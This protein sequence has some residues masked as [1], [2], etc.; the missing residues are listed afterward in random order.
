M[1]QTEYPGFLGRM[2]IRD[3]PILPRIGLLVS[4][5]VVID[6]A[7][8]FGTRL[9]VEDYEAPVFVW[10]VFFH[11]YFWPSLVLFMIAGVTLRGRLWTDWQSLALAPAIR[12]YIFGLALLLAW[13]SAIYA[14]NHFAD[15]AHWL[16]RALVV[17]SL[18]LIWVRPVFVFPFLVMCYLSMFQLVAPGLGGPIIAHKL[19]VFQL[20]TAFGGWFLLRLW[21]RSFTATDLLF[22]FLCIIAGRYW[23]PGLAKVLLGWWNAGDITRG[24]LGSWVHGWL[25]HLSADGIVALARRFEPYATILGA[26]VLV[27][28]LG[29]L[30]IL[31]HRR[32]AIALLAF[33][34]VFHSGVFFLLGFMFWIWVTVDF[35][36]ICLL[37]WLG[38]QS[39]PTPFL[40]P[41]LL[42]SI[43]LIALSA[44]W[45]R[46]PHLGWFD[47]GLTYN[48]RITAIGESGTRYSVPPMVFAPFNDLFT[49]NAFNYLT[50]EYNHLTASYGITT[51]REIAH[52]I[53]T[54]RSAEE[55]FAL[56]R[57]W[58]G[59][60][61][62]D[63][64]RA[65]NFYR[66]VTQHFANLNAN[67]PRLT[68]LSRIEPPVHFWALAGPDAYEGQEPV[69]AV[70]FTGV[71]WFFDGT[72]L[73]K[74]RDVLLHR[75]EVP[76]P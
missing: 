20:L 47:T 34:I 36:T 76:S 9:S 71:T 74:I 31:A 51:S 19:I 12:L 30:F 44:F 41:Y 37:I 22:V 62:P 26:I 70:E 27:A 61:V 17:V 57:Q 52:G 38:R 63:A 40:R 64:V 24:F 29:A 65:E 48:V 42:V 10:R 11:P 4:V 46:P 55:I 33:F 72:A 16:D 56:E 66:F 1:V 8:F 3:L 54:A 7:L 21:N 28:E 45:S 39:G 73:T 23:E 14:Y 58:P 60:N 53:M 43:P 6:L 67:G 68:G 15:Q 13:P 75:A 49:M 5:F 18:G 35:A 59:R 25:T 50:D 32:L 69:K 2:S